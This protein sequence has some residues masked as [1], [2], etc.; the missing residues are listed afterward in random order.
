MQPW[1]F[2]QF[3]IVNDYDFTY[4]QNDA[5]TNA[6]V[7]QNGVAAIFNL[8]PMATA[9]L[10]ILPTF[11]YRSEPSYKNVMPVSQYFIPRLNYNNFW[12]LNHH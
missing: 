9:I 7:I 4:C 8:F 1:F 2:K 10:N 3:N 6:H 11:H 12:S 5:D